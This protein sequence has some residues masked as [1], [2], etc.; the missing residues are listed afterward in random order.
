MLR[1]K[2]LI[3]KVIQIKGQCPVYQVSDAFQIMNGFQLVAD[4]PYV[5]IP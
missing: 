2:T 5:C 4:K 3:I 1:A